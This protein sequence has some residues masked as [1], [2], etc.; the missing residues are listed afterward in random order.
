V[1]LSVALVGVLLALP[2]SLLVVERGALASLP[3]GWRG[4]AREHLPGAARRQRGQAH[5][6]AA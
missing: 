1:D 3:G 2:A 6:E 4:A 5:H